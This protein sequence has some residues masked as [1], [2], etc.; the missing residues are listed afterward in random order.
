MTTERVEESGAA[1]RALEGYGYGYGYAVYDPDYAFGTATN[2]VAGDNYKLCWA[3]DP[4]S[5]ASYNVEIDSNAELVGPSRRTSLALA[6]S[7]YVVATQRL[8][9]APGDTAIHASCHV[10]LLGAG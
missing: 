6:V 7:I 2:G 4:T 1:A 5:I 9:P 3:H 10:L 8:M